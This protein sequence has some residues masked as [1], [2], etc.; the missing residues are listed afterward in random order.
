MEKSLLPVL[1]KLKESSAASHPAH[2]IVPSMKTLRN[3]KTLQKFI[4]I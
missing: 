1:I 3:G 2:R 4:S